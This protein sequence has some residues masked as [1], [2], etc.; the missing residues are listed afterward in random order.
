MGIFSKFFGGSD[1]LDKAEAGA[2]K[3]KKREENA[4]RRAMANPAVISFMQ[5]HD[6]TEEHVK[7]L[8]S[9]L[10]ALGIPEEE[11]ADQALLNIELLEW[12]FSLPDPNK[13]TFEQS[14]QL[15]NWVRYGRKE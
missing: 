14:I 5:E 2:A 13:L 9:R 10:N 3:S 4:V 7:A 8:R 12:F 11:R 15:T 1:W 6:L